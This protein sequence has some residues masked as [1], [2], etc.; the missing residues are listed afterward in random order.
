MFISI[1]EHTV[2]VENERIFNWGKKIVF[3][4]EEKKAASDGGAA[5]MAQDVANI[6]CGTIGLLA[7]V[8][9]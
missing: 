7:R 5:I 3:T 1:S 4:S 6:V 2:N 9:S 8:G